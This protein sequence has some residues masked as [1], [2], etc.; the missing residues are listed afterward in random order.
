MLDCFLFLA[1]INRL[2]PLFVIFFK[3]VPFNVLGF[4]RKNK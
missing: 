1:N 3:G 2:L 4:K